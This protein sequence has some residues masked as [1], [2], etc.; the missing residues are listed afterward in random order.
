M[1]RRIGRA[2][3]LDIYGALLTPRQ[4]EAAR[5][6]IDEDCSLQEIAELLGVTRQGAHEAVK[7]AADRLEAVEGA[8]RLAAKL[9]AARLAASECRRLLSRVK[10]AEGTDRELKGA[11]IELDKIDN[12]EAIGD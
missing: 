7:R 11:M 10:A 8:L 12:I 4:R 9:D 6:S 3:L 2:R 1:E 5:L